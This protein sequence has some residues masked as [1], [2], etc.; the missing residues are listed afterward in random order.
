VGDIFLNGMRIGS[1][2]YG[3]VGFQ[4]D[5]TNQLKEGDNVLMVKASTM[6][7][8]NSRWYTGGGLYRN[9]NL[10]K[11]SADL[12]F[13]RHPLYITT[14]DNRLVQITAELTNRTKSRTVRIGLKIYDPQGKMVYENIDTRRRINPSRTMEARL[15]EVEIPNPKLWDTEH[16]NLYTA[17]VTLMREDGSVA[18]EVSEPFGIRTIEIGPDFGLKLNGKKVLLKGYANHH[19]LGALGR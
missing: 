13:E 16:P 6:N 3:Y 7:E 5:I 2:D 18:D 12:Y 11:T 14:R 15:T 19:T 17:V 4:I 10:I 9:V 1:T 8:K